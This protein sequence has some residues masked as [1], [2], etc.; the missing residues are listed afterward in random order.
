MR[1][2]TAGGGAGDGD[3]GG[4][5]WLSACALVWFGGML[6]QWPPATGGDAAAERAFAAWATFGWPASLMLCALGKGLLLFGRRTLAIR[7]TVER[8]DIA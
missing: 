5:N 4:G 6:L 1:R 3:G 7:R 8:T 2:V